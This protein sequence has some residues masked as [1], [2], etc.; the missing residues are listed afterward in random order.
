MA[1]GPTGPS[2]IHSCPWHCLGASARW[3]HSSLP[4]HF[5]PLL[6]QFISLKNAF[7]KRPFRASLGSRIYAPFTH[8]LQHEQNLS[9]RPRHCNSLTHSGPHGSFYVTDSRS[10]QRDRILCSVTRQD[11]SRSSDED[12]DSISRTGPGSTGQSPPEAKLS[13]PNLDS[14]EA[15][16]QCEGNSQTTNTASCPRTGGRTSN[17]SCPIRHQMALDF[18]AEGFS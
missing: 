18:G 6:L 5:L 14:G 16:S 1:R 9:P 12:S 17:P 8:G 3:F 13:S 4:I 10:A 15:T 11:D 2:C 7:A